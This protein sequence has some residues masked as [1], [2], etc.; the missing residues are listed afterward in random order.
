M[1]ETSIVHNHHCHIL[2]LKFNAS[3]VVITITHKSCQLSIAQATIHFP[4]SWEVVGPNL[5]IRSG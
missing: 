1:D 2:G 5:P 3:F 4:P